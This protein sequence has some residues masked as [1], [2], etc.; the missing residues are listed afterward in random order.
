MIVPRPPRAVGADPEGMKTV[1]SKT[2][3]DAVLH[4]L[5]GSPWPRAAEG[6]SAVNKLPIPTAHTERWKYTRVGK[7]FN[8]P[9][10]APVSNAD[11]ELPKRLPFTATRMVFVNGHYR[12]DLSDDLKQTKGIVID[13]ITNHLGHGPFKEYYGNIAPIADRLFTAMNM[14]RPTD[15]MILLATKGTQ[16][17]QPL[18]VLHINIGRG[19]LVQPRNLLML[20]EKAEVEVIVEQITLGEAQ[21]DKR[22]QPSLI[23]T[24]TEIIVGEQARLTIHKLQHEVGGPVEID[25]DSA[26]V[27]SGGWL[28]MD[29]VTLEGGLVRNEIAV[30]LM[31]P[32]AHVELNGAYLLNGTTHCDNHTYIGHDAPDCTSDELYKGIVA[33]KATGV[34][35]GKVFVKQDAQRTRAYQSNANILQGDDARVFTKPALEIYADDVKCSHGCTIGRLDDQA[36]FYLRSRGISEFEARNLMA[37]AFI[38]NVLDRIANKDWL[39]HVLEAVDEKLDRQ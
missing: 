12:A 27:M 8:K 37:H 28:S 20:H 30:S 25:L 10:V 1:P 16:L 14:A 18:H 29:T 19:M 36:L 13:T 39:A 22:L 17:G 7:L 35:D 34:F 21:E 31:G 15:G 32:N 26:R 2:P 33:G 6:S 38:T 4:V 24:V 23:N 5:D 9:Y 11:V 3:K